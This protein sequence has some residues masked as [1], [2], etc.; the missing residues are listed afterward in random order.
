MHE[1]DVIVVGAGPAGSTAAAA[2][3]RRGRDVVLL[4]RAA[5]PRDKPCGD[6]IPPG[7]VG[8]LHDLGLRDGLGA[9]GFARVRAVRLVSRLAHTTEPRL[10]ELPYAIASR[11][12]TSLVMSTF[13]SPRTPRRPNRVRAPRASHTIDDVTSAPSSTI[14][15]G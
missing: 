15:D 4:D 14:F 10:S 13:A 1:H 12:A 3:A 5:F 8:I 2:L 9:A 11:T 7:T 6:G